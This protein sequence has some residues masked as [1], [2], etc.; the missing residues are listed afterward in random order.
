MHRYNESQF[1]VQ[2]DPLV[3]LGSLPLNYTMSEK[4]NSLKAILSILTEF[5]ILQNLVRTTIQ[6]G[7][8]YLKMHI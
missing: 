5:T 7:F 8:A 1:L 6:L 4:L 2:H 3:L